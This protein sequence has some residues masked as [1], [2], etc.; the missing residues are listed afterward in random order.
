VKTLCSC[1]DCCSADCCTAW[2]AY[3]NMVL[4]GVDL[5]RAHINQPVLTAQA[6]SHGTYEAGFL[7][8]IMGLHGTAEAQ[9]AA[10]AAAEAAV[11]GRLPQAKTAAAAEDAAQA[12]LDQAMAQAAAVDRFAQS[13]GRYQQATDAYA[14]AAEAAAKSAAAADAVGNNAVASTQQHCA[15]V[16]ANSAETAAEQTVRTAAGAVAARRHELDAALIARVDAADAASLAALTAAAA[17]PLPP[18]G[19]P[20]V[21]VPAASASVAKAAAASRRAATAAAEAHAATIA[22]AVAV[23]G[24]RRAQQTAAQ[25]L[26]TARAADSHTAAAQAAADELM[27]A[28]AGASVDL[29]VAAAAAG[30]AKL[31]EAAAKAAFDGAAADVAAVGAQSSAPCI[32]AVR[33][34]SIN[35]LTDMEL[36]GFAAALATILVAVEQPGILQPPGARPPPPAAASQ[37]AAAQVAAKYTASH[38][39]PEGG[40]PPVCSMAGCGFRWAAVGAAPTADQT[41]PHISKTRP[42]LVKQHNSIPDELQGVKCCPPA[43][44]V[45]HMQLYLAFVLFL[46]AVGAVVIATLLC[47]EGVVLASAAGWWQSLLVA[48]LF[49]ILHSVPMPW[50]G[51]TTVS[52]A[53][54]QWRNVKA[55]LQALPEHSHLARILTTSGVEFWFDVVGEGVICLVSCGFLATFILAMVQEHDCAGV[56]PA[57]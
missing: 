5:L 29:L 52:A 8:G 9:A 22:A 20:L 41:I 51:N 24:A 25:Q 18:A 11:G 53:H 47:R 48:V 54:L 49:G 42:Q 57:R 17:A 3:I 44:A 40:G 12:G 4:L 32:S 38:P 13:T 14:A 28:A 16:A 34:S 56:L 27:L 35:S 55:A 39:A 26:M 2:L 23:E 50:F 7:V 45:R 6:K 19:P 46:V 30:D 36:F 37:A 21:A 10:T 33:Y 43:V 15:E 31:A 1:C